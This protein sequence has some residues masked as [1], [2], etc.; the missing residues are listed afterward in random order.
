LATAATMPRRSLQARV[1]TKRAGSAGMNGI[2][3]LVNNCEHQ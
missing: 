3:L 2:F 1:S